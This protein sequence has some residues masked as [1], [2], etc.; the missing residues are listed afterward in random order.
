MA[1]LA[2]TVLTRGMF[3]QSLRQ[4]LHALSSGALP[5]L[6][7]GQEQDKA[8]DDEASELWQFVAAAL[9]LFDDSV[10]DQPGIGYYGCRLSFGR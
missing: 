4:T 2:T 10:D 9:K 8:A 7:F 3:D 5:F 6:L 1:V